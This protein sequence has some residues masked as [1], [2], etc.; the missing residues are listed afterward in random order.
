MVGYIES[1]LIIIL[2][3]MSCKVFY[4]IFGEKRRENGSLREA[5]QVIL[6]S[7]ITLIISIIFS[8]NLAIKTVVFIFEIAVAMYLIMEISFIKAL[9]LSFFFDGI[10]LVVEYIIFLS[11]RTIFQDIDGLGDMGDI[12]GILL[13]LLGEALL[14]LILMMINRG[15]G[16]HSKVSLGNQEWLSFIFVPVLTIGTI[17]VMLL[18]IEKPQMQSRDFIY[19]MIAFALVGMNIVVFQL[20]NNILKREEKIRKDQIFMLKMKN[21]T[22]MYYSISENLEKHRE[23]AHEYKNQIF[24]MTSLLQKKKYR[25][26][27]T[28][29]GKINRE[30][31]ARLDAIQTNHVIVDAILN[32]KYQEMTEKN[33]IFVFRINDLSGISL[34]DE[35]IVVILSNL[36]NNAI[37]ACEKCQGKKVI[38]LK[39]LV[40]DDAIILSVKNTY[41]NPLNMQNG[42]YQTTKSQDDEHGIG[43][44]NIVNVIKRY[45]G[46]YV[47]K[48][49]GLEFLFSI[50]IPI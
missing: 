21:Q 45:G 5:F 32:T 23:K 29:I 35:D 18:V 42:E 3:M 22:Q 39:F 46:S 41:E 34:S 43:I 1:F 19:F 7:M 4:G 49:N 8:H 50:F 16:R 2:E 24:C 11:S 37:E 48:H 44:R 36:L 13:I 31:D 38:K 12:R 40:E 6:L 27:E 10:L 47:V 26:L 17:F 15:I 30:L 33:I 28:Y 20:I 14:L 25:E 9:I